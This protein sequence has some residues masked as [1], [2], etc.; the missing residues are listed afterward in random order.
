[1]GPLVMSDQSDALAEAIERIERFELADAD[2]RDDQYVLD[3]KRVVAAARQQIAPSADNSM[4]TVPVAVNAAAAPTPYRTF[5]VGGAMG[6]AADNSKLI[7]EIDNLIADGQSANMPARILL[8]RCRSA[9]E[10][11]A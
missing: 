1:M 8:T 5:K 2:L 7:A 11:K 9:L 10:S 6:T 3:L 4:L